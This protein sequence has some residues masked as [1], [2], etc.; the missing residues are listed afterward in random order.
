[1]KGK[2]L[3]FR[4]V[5]SKESEVFINLKAEKPSRLLGVVLLNPARLDQEGNPVTR[6]IRHS[7]AKI[8][9][10][11]DEDILA[12]RQWRLAKVLDLLS[13]DEWIMNIQTY[14]YGKGRLDGHNRMRWQLVAYQAQ[15]TADQIA[16]AKMGNEVQISLL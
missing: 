15:L 5:S 6:D 11:R 9:N 8:E 16:Q 12:L 4:C 1:M 7:E 2:A 10:L 14:R 3:A 13:R